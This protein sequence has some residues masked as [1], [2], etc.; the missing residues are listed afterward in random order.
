MATVMRDF[1]RIIGIDVMCCFAAGLVAFFHFGFAK[2]CVI[3]LLS[4]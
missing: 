2:R 4:P 1:N 3:Y